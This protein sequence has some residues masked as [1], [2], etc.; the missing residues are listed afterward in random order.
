MILF[1]T[2]FFL[3]NIQPVSPGVVNRQPQLATG[4]GQVALT[5]AA[6]HSIYFASSA[7][8]G[9][10]FSH[11]IKVAD[12]ENLMA[13]RHRG[14]R[15]VILK[16][17]LVI[18]AVAGAS[19]EKADLLVWRSV[20]HGKTWQRAGIINDIPGAAREGLHAMAA[21]A[22][23][24]IFA[25]W[26][27]LRKPGT[28]L[29]GSRSTD[30]GLSW[31]KNV[32]IYASP[33]GSICQCC[34]PSLTIDNKGQVWAM[35]R[36]LI[37]GARDLY[38]ASSRDSVQ[39]SE[40]EKL[41][42]GTWN[43]NACPMDGG[44]LAVHKGQLVSAWRRDGEIFLAEPGRPESRVGKGKDVAIA[45]GGRGVFVAWSNGSAIEV[46]SPGASEP[47][48]LSN[49]GAFVDLLAL[50]DG[51]ALAAWEANGTIQ[52]ARITAAAAN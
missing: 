34:A 22:N 16:D 5:F 23:G 21:D 4:Y 20:D 31:S 44:G 45:A 33:G 39:F 13:G 41:G 43:L 28:Q 38:A 50:P 10:T 2:S 46:L 15:I 37:N 51:S 32:L 52:T 1:L 6:G 42:E 40:A 24:N 9:G 8:Q 27:D 25:A 12:A 35:W 26:L 18:S 49:A 36:N 30:G 3:M 11:P 47:T 48:T 29:Y 19:P 17:A 7:D 14:P